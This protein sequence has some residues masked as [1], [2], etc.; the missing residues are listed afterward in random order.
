MTWDNWAKH[1]WHIDHIRPLVSFDLTDESQLKEAM[2]YT[3][4]QPLW[5]EDNHRKHAKIGAALD[6]LGLGKDDPEHFR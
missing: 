4:L 3:N 5:A 6:K 2:H 1:G